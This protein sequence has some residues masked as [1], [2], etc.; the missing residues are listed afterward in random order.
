LAVASAREVKSDRDSGPRRNYT[1]F[2][3]HINEDLRNHQHGV[4]WEFASDSTALHRWAERMKF[5]FKLQV[6]RPALMFDRLRRGSRGRFR[7]DRNGFGL[8]EEF[9]LN[10]DFLEQAPKWA[11]LGILLWLLLHAWQERHGKPGKGRYH[12]VQ[13]R[14]KA[15]SLGL[16]VDAQ[17]RTRYLPGDTP[18]LRLLRKYGVQVPEEP[19]LD[20]EGAF[21]L[22]SLLCACS[23]S[24]VQAQVVHVW[25]LPAP[26]EGKG[27]GL[28]IQ[29][30]LFGLRR[31][32]RV[33]GAA[34][35]GPGP[36]R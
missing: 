33:T 28:A 3:E 9:G 26:G 2:V 5:A 4:D 36:N 29:C 1:P 15:L 8:R 7:P 19:I 14:R 30:P 25:L 22:S 24:R 18:F 32:V 6:S 27:R 21:S 10:K 12:N 23:G 17:G 13:F 11:V 16:L 34:R 20:E 35:W 31:D